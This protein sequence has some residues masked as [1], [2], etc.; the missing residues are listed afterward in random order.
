MRK[1]VW[2]ARCIMVTGR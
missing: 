2:E 1:R